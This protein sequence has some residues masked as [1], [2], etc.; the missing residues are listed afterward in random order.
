[1]GQEGARRG[2]GMMLRCLR[3]SRSADPGILACLSPHPAL[4]SHGIV[5][6]ATL[7][8][9]PCTRV[10][11]GFVVSCL[12]PT[13]W[14]SSASSLP[15]FHQVPLALRGPAARSQNKSRELEK[16]KVERQ[17]LQR[18]SVY[19]PPTPPA[20]QLHAT[21]GSGPTLAPAAQT[22]RVSLGWQQRSWPPPPRR[23]SCS[24]PASDGSPVTTETG[25]L[26]S[27]FPPAARAWVSGLHR[28][29][30]RTL[31]PGRGLWLPRIRV[32]LSSHPG[33]IKG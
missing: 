21:A 13:L 12:I 30:S 31:A 23:T 6:T 22:P 33:R 9:P 5:L 1:M 8:D 27:P 18:G 3:K 14:F 16:R 24:S 19:T 2:F 11:L 32:Q 4:G 25:Q 20:S 7:P 17:W 10:L 26:T 29:G 28:L 15:S